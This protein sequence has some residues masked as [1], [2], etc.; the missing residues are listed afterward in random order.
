MEGS[1]WSFSII[2][3]NLVPSGLSGATAHV[4]AQI[5]MD[6]AAAIAAGSTKSASPVFLFLAFYTLALASMAPSFFVCVDSA[7]IRARRAS[8][9]SRK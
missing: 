7:G 9:E 4:A 2:V 5:H 6:V 8:S 1:T 3:V